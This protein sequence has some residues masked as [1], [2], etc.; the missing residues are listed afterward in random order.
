MTCAIG[1]MRGAQEFKGGPVGS[2]AEPT[3]P[4]CARRPANALTLVGIP[5]LTA[6]KH[7]L[8]FSAFNKGNR[9]R[10]VRS[11]CRESVV[12]G[13]AVEVGEVDVRE[14]DSLGLAGG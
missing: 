7:D 10:S 6:G 11:W 12:S 8:L 9:F 2:R 1:G 4:R 13:E 3:G 5:P 14:V